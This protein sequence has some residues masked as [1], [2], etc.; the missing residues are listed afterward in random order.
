MG[1]ELL[2]LEVSSERGRRTL[3]IYLDKV[4]GGVTVEDCALFSRAL[5]PVLDVEGGIAGS[6]DLEVSSPGLN[7]P[8]VQ[9]E[10][11]RNQ[12]GSVLQVATREPVGGR[13]NFKGPL[14]SVAGEGEDFLLKLKVDREIFEIPWRLIH[15][16]H[17]DYFATEEIKETTYAA[18]Q[19]KDRKKER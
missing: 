3:R 2:L 17:L 9:P 1:Y 15:R 12:I 16:A 18:A 10:H 7:R 14:E 11:F 6:Y 8:L 4:P 13:R 19:K 5:G